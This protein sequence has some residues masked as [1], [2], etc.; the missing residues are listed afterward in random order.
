PHLRRRAGVFD[1]LGLR[2]RRHDDRPDADHGHPASFRLLWWLGTV[3]VLL[4]H[5]PGDQRRAAPRRATM[6]NTENVSEDPARLSGEAA[7]EQVAP[8]P[9]VPCEIA[10]VDVHLP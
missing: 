5:W 10:S 9:F 4:G 6:T 3:R 7:A 8:K 1:L 2:E